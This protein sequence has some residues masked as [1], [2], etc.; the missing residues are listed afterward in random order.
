MVHRQTERRK[1]QL[2]L[3]DMAYG[4]EAVGRLDN[5]VVFASFG[6]PGEVVEVEV[7]AEKKD[8]LRGNVTRVLEP[9]P[10][11]A[12]PRCK[13]FGQCGGCQWQHVDYWKQ[14]DLKRQIV[15]DQM[16]RVGRFAD[17]EVR[18]T[19]GCE[20]PW[21]YRNHARF[22]VGR[23]QGDVGF[24]RAGTHQILR[25]DDCHLM[26]PAINEVL[27]LVQGAKH[28]H[29]IMVRCGVHTGQILINPKL[30]LEGFSMESGQAFLEEKLLGRTFRISAASFF[31]VNTLQA[32]VMAREVIRLLDPSP[33][34]TVIDAYCGVGTFGLLLADHAGRVIGIE[35]SA[36]AIT[37]AQHN[38]QG[39]RNVE[40]V[41]G[42]TEKL[43]REVAQPGALVIL[44]PPRQGCRP[45]AIESLASLRPRRIVYISCDPV[46]L[47][48]DLR[49][50]GDRG[51]ALKHVQPV[52]MFPQTYHIEC[53]ALLEDG[54]PSV[55]SEYAPRQVALGL[56]ME[57]PAVGKRSNASRLFL[58]SS[59]PRRQEIMRQ[60]GLDY[61]VRSADVDETPLPGEEPQETAQRLAS[62][63]ASA[64]ALSQAAGIVVAADTIVVV[65]NR[66]LG[67]PASVDEARQM[68]R[69]LRNR[70]HQ[71]ITGV[72][73]ENAE[74]HE[75]CVSSVTTT[76]WM[77]DYSDAE[78]EDYVRSGE[79]M[80]KAGAY[81]IQST[82]M[83]LVDRIEGCYL[84]VVG[85]PACELIRGLESVGYAITTT[86]REKVVEFCQG[87][88]ER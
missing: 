72:A 13:H 66:I 76:V 59:S 69:L 30:D 25:V 4:G 82:R 52:D 88:Q 70:S 36:A 53:V 65:D 37:N 45:E 35:D 87:C 58:A 50:L 2:K 39:I 57:R 34:D 16:R 12:D 83:R 62:A 46:T 15:L 11:R 68:L 51:F 67:K 27:A 1:I 29:Q 22:S 41:D 63:K 61:E 7:Y 19:I 24:T 9:S 56:P 17:V 5:R 10:F 55:S 43:L 49:L 84:N 74:T 21:N 81:A 48:R 73:V 85:L 80:D 47:A 28:L 64:A 6:L 42:P 44:D 54:M 14:L 78:I 20:A 75:R 79:P 77:R 33:E 18:P 86:T 8:F 38:A 26:Y 60:M 31:Q 3:H 32:E 23:R 40:F 71:V